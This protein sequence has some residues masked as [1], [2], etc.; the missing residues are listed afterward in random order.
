[1][2]IYDYG[3][4][5]NG[6]LYYVMEYLQGLDAESLVHQYGPQPAG[7]VIWFLWQACES[8]EEAHYAGLVHRD[9]KASN[10]FICRLGKRTDFVKMLDFGLVKDLGG[11]TKDA[12]TATQART[13]GTPAFMAPEQV[14]G[15]DVDPRTDIYGL[16]CLAYYLLTGTVLFN[17][18]SPMSMALAHLTD[19]PEPPSRRSELPI[20]QS[21]ERVVMACL[22]KRRENRP[23]S[24]A[25]LLKMLDGCSDVTPWTAAEADQWW[26][27]HRPGPVGKVS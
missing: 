7:R 12:L 2:A 21:L 24:V 27:L 13:A 19:R 3:V 20:P 1:V 9:I 15:G 16:G 26:A 25:A 11:A 14:T 5:E 18:P 17:K 8:L 4:A 10:L 22:E 6:S 23:Q